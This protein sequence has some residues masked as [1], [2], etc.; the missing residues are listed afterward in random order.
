[1][2]TIDQDIQ[3]N[4]LKHVYLLYGEERYLLL[5]Y[6]D[7]LVNALS[8]KDD[9]MNFTRFEGDDISENEIIDLAETLPFFTDK[10]LILVE[11][12]PFFSANSDKIVEYMSQIPDTTYFVFCEKTADKRTRL[13]KAISKVGSAIEFK[14]MDEKTLQT[15]I[16]SR[17]K[18]NNKQITGAVLNLFLS[19]TGD[20][21]GTIDMELEKLISYVGDRPVITEEDIMA[22]TSVKI[23]DK[24]FDMIDA[25]TVKNQKLALSLY[26]DLLT[27]KVAPVKTLKLIEKQYQRLFI[28]KSMANAS[29]NE[30]A[31]KA[32]IPSFFV[33]KY[34]AQCKSYS[35]QKLR[36]ILQTISDLDYS[37]KSGNLSDQLAVELFIVKYAAS[38]K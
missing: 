29:S 35:M 28:V 1:M 18:K 2:K 22:I 34:V 3:N 15:W 5:Q 20:D 21:M 30:I 37:F 24:V 11:N 19:R 14:R 38:T 6:R 25:I 8:T 36:E 32:G 4:N 13:Y 7:K 10:R 12:A 26:S 9:T 17:L 33:K 23:E 27:L 16:V 31:T